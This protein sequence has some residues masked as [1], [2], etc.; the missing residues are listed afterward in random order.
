MN[1]A[2]SRCRV[3]RH[4]W[5]SA[6]AAIYLSA[7]PVGCPR[8]EP[9]TVFDGPWEP[10]PSHSV[11]ACTFALDSPLPAPFPRSSSGFYGVEINGLAAPVSSTIDLDGG[12]ITIREP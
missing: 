3:Q 2:N 12:V 10:I 5:G 1:V 7:C 11:G 6:A 8:A 4:F 9:I